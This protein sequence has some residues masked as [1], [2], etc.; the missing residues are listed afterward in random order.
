M[1]TCEYPADMWIMQLIKVKTLGMVCIPVH[2]RA[3]S[4]IQ[5]G[6]ENNPYSEEAA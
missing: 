1:E 3:L 5:L 4:F 6:E 2:I